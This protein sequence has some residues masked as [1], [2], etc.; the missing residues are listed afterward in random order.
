M[1]QLIQILNGLSGSYFEFV[2]SVAEYAEGKPSHL[3][4]MM[5]FLH[6]NPSATPS[7]V[8]RFMSF[9]DDFFEDNVSSLVG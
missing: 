2:D 9:Q 6:N 1:E 8:L 7:D 5:D 3:T 4:I